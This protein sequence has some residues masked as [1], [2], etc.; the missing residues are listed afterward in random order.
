M[1]WAISLCYTF[2]N[3][4]WNNA[5]MKQVQGNGIGH[6]CGGVST[7]WVSV[8]GDFIKPHTANK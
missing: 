8:G 4:I 3:N 6:E 1:S 7:L 5:V 2:Q